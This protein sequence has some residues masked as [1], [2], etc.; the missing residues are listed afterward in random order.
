MVIN[1]DLRCACRTDNNIA[2]NVEPLQAKRPRKPDFTPAECAV[3][4]EEAEENL[5]ILK[6]KFSST[7]SSYRRK[8]LLFQGSWYRWFSD[9]LLCK[10]CSC[11]PVIFVSF[12]RWVKIYTTY[13]TM[14]KFIRWIASG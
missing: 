4:F 5:S 3:I 9:R 8:V 6:S 12:I 13:L 1:P 11:R 7:L 10:R 2:E 14:D